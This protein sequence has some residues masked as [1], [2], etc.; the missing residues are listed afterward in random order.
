[1]GVNDGKIDCLFKER[2]TTK[3][4]G[5][6]IGLVTCQRIA[7]GHNGSIEYSYEDGAVF[8]V[9]LPLSRDQE[10]VTVPSKAAPAGSPRN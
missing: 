10:A 9:F 2:F 8:T 7:D 4:K 1:P 5:H 6:G 3:R